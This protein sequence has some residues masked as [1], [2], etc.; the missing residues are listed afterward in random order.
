[1]RIIMALMLCMALATFMVACGVS[2]DKAGLGAKVP[3]SLVK[4]VGGRVCGNV[5]KITVDT[6][7][8]TSPHPSPTC[9]RYK[10]RIG[11]EEN[12]G[13]TVVSRLKRQI[14]KS[15]LRF[16]QVLKTKT[17]KGEIA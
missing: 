17:R 3:S 1:M 6:V 4:T 5:E 16:E 8:S 15:T 12:A 10:I 14:N 2:A 7:H 11:A 9:L 13:E